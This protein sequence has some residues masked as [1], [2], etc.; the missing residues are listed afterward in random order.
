MGRVLLGML[1]GIVLVPVAALT[2][3]KYGHP[4]VSVRDKPFPLEQ[5]AIGIPLQARIEFEQVSNPP[6]KPGEDTYRFL[7]A[8]ALRPETKAPS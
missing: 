4:P 8:P 2:Y 5:E 3:L 6:V 1:I 7:W